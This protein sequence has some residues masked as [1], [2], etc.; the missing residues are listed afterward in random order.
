M[1]DGVNN[2]PHEQQ[3]DIWLRKELCSIDTVNASNDEYVQHKL[4]SF[5]LD[6]IESL[7]FVLCILFTE[8]GC[9][10]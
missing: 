2:C 1:S 5:V 6:L 10:I 4:V 8:F 7:L 9:G 3:M